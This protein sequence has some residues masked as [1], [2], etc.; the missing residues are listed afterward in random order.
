M[1]CVMCSNSTTWTLSPYYRVVDDSGT[2]VHPNLIYLPHDDADLAI[3][4]T[5]LTDG[6]VQDSRFEEGVSR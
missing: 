4:Q 6:S 3:C 2:A 5:C 1:T